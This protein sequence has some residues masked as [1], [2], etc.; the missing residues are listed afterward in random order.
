VS[1]IKCVP[2]SVQQLCYLIL[3]DAVRGTVGSRGKQVAVGQHVAVSL[4]WLKLTALSVHL[5]SVLE[6]RF[7]MWVH[8]TEN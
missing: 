5:K 1:S 4:Y 8:S 3:D 7:W 2:F 6:P